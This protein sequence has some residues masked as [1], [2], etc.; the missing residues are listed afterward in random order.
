[1]DIGNTITVIMVKLEIRGLKVYY[2]TSKGTVKA[3]DG[4]NMNTSE[5][6]GIVGE[7]GSGKSTLAYAIMRMLQYPARIVEGSIILD[8]TDILAM[9][10]REFNEHIRWKKIAMV[11]QYAMNSLDPVYK[12]K[13]QMYEV[14]SNHGVDTIDDTILVDALRETGLDAN[15]LE[16]Y[17]HE[18][19]GG[20]KQRVVIA[21]ALLLKPSILIADEPTTA[22][23]VLVQAQ[24]MNMLKRLKSDGLMII[25]ITHDLSIVAEVVDRV[26]IMYAGQIVEFNK[27]DVIFKEAKHPYTQALMS[28]IPRLKGEKRLSYI[29]G[30]P[31]NPFDYPKGCRFYA[32][33]PYAM[34]KCM[35]EPPYI[36]IGD[37]YVRC[38]LYK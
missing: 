22:L 11:F 23:D 17:P 37:G 24:I 30:D 27:A 16:Y 1:M 6:V 13:D 3:V 12:V 33:C 35:Q 26:A 34:D 10:E 28:S 21:M 32:R 38:W 29:K 20:M 4:I 9:N 15:V 18:L 19:S 36:S 14:L 7:S 2:Y 8:G 5:S 31:P 25:L